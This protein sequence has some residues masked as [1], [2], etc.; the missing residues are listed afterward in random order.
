MWGETVTSLVN[1]SMDEFLEHDQHNRIGSRKNLEQYWVHFQDL[2]LIYSELHTSID[3]NAF[4]K[5]ETTALFYYFGGSFVNLPKAV[6]NLMAGHI[7]DATI[8][9]QKPSLFV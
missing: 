7:S 8:L 5:T 4:D 6:S 3:R 9:L 2:A 1:F